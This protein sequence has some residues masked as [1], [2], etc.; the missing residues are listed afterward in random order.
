M[1]TEVS[2]GDTPV[3]GSMTGTFLGEEV[4]EV[5]F[6][7]SASHAR[8]ASTASR[9]D[10]ASISLGGVESA[11]FADTAS[12][13]LGGI[14]SATFAVTAAFTETASIATTAE[15]ASLAETASFAF[16]A[17][18]ASFVESASF[19]DRTIV[20]EIASSSFNADTASFVTASNIQGVVTSASLAITASFVESASF[21]DRTIVAEVA[22]RSF[23]SD[24]ASFV[25][26]SNIQGVVGSA[27]LAETASLS[28]AALSAPLLIPIP[29]F[30]DQLKLIDIILGAESQFQLNLTNH[31]FSR[32]SIAVTIPDDNGGRPRVAIQYSLNQTDWFFLDGADGPY[33]DITG[34]PGLNIRV[35][36]PVVAHV[37][38]SKTDV[39]LRA[40]TYSGS[41]SAPFESPVC[42]GMFWFLQI[43]EGQ[44]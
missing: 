42:F 21:A 23:N 14:E 24:T 20:A 35:A 27:S 16:T 1:T 15:T 7:G 11:S 17:E 28:A 26:A 36:G 9:A 41:V 13:V 5:S 8:N 12:I 22:T 18:T 31:P 29:S 32:I 25:T 4:G 6:V 38:E 37:S 30:L 43:I 44:F 34:S 40:I 33:A 3:T 39:F 10:T 19:A 2:F